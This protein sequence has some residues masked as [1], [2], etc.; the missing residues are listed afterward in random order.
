MGNGGGA[1]APGESVSRTVDE[2][3]GESGFRKAVDEM[4]GGS[5][6]GGGIKPSGS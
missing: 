6:G 1:G 2:V 3:L 5:G 4:D